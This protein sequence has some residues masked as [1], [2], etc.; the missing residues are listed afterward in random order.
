MIFPIVDNPL[1]D[2]VARTKEEAPA[3]SLGSAVRGLWLMTWRP[4]VAWRHL[5]AL[6]A[7][8]LA[9]PALASMAGFS[10]PERAARFFPWVVVF[11]FRVALPL[12]CLSILGDVVRG[13]LQTNTLVFLATRPL[14]RARLF[15][16]K[17]ACEGLWVQI[18]AAGSMALLL[19]I[20]LVLHVPSIASIAL[21]LFGIQ[22][23]AVLAY[24]AL[25]ALLGLIHRR[26][27]V[28][29]A[30][31]GLVVEVGIGQIPTNVN[32]LSIARHLRTLLANIPTFNSTYQWSPDGTLTSL[33][34][35]PI[36][37]AILTAVAAAF[38]TW[39]EYH[40]NEEMHR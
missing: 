19:S 23:L 34:V 30:I 4:R 37:A 25:S 6:L 20:G 5:P 16:L 13:E 31:Y 17:L 10:H 22:F 26:F 27:L 38:F 8:L 32:N 40:Y 36:A 39:R 35:L 7:T 14:T 11:H 9:I 3:P 18:I 2:S 15:L 24:G 12:Y 28:V 1:P 21:K 33:L 29:G